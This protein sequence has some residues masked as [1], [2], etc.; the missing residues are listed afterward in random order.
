MENERQGGTNATV[1]RVVGYEESEDGSP[2]KPIY[3]DLGPGKIVDRRVAKTMRGGSKDTGH[4][5]TQPL[6]GRQ[7]DG[8][9]IYRGSNEPR[10]RKKGAPEAETTET[11]T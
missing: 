5:A 1:K 8:G 4:M 2:R 9:N 10:S 7:P 6:M 3:E 11:D